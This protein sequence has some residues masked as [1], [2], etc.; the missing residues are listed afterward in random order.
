MFVC[1][2]LFFCLFVCLVCLTFLVTTADECNKYHWKLTI[3]YLNGFQKSS[4][5]KIQE[6]CDPFQ[7]TSHIISVR[8]E[9]VRFKILRTIGLYA[10]TTHEAYRLLLHGSI[11]MVNEKYCF[12]VCLLSL[13]TL[14]FRHIIDLEKKLLLKYDI[15]ECTLK[16]I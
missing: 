3:N 14:V 12:F 10:A 16:Y 15:P 8:K 4:K 6:I 5:Y 11:I 1:L 9:L 7:Q 13:D 2:F